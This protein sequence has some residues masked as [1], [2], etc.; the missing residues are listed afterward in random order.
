MTNFV[1]LHTHSD[2]SLLD[3]ACSIS[4]L[5][6][7]AYKLDMPALALTDHGNL[8]GAIDFYQKAKKRKLK[9]LI[10]CEVYVAPTSRFKKKKIG[11]QPTAYHLT[12]LAK[13]KKGYEN[14]M[15]LITGGY[16]EGFYYHPRVDKEF[17]S[18]KGEGLIVLSGCAK[19]EIP[20]LLSQNKVDKAKEICQF[21]KN[22][23]GED[24]YLEVQDVGLEFQKKINS[25]LANLSQE[26]SIPLVAT[27][28][29][30]YLN[31]ED[32]QAQDVLL[33][34][35]TGKTLDDTN[36]LKFSSS[37]L[38]FRSSEEMEK[39]FSHLPQSISNA[40]LISEKCNLELE[41][42]K[43]H[44]PVYRAPDGHNL[45]K[46]LRKLCQERLPHCYPTASAS[47]EQRLETELSIISK[48]GYTGYF[49][50]VWDFISYAKK[51]KI[52]IGPGRG[53]VTGSIVAYLLG[54]TN[55]NPLAY[56]LL[57]ERFLN[58][59]RTAM[60]DI[61]IDIQDERRNEVISYVREKYG[62]ENVAQIITFGTMAARA[63][64]RDVGRV[65]GI[66][67]SR[68]DRIA[69]LIPFNT[70]LKIAIEE[71]SEL[72]EIL[73]EDGKIKTLFEIAQSIEG[74]TRHASTHAAGVVIAPD[75][76]TYYTPLYRTNKNEITTQYEMHS[77]EAIGLLKMDFLGLKTLNVIGDALKIIK[78]NKGKE[79]DLDRISLEDKKAY[80]LLSQ[81]E[82][83]GVFQV[84]SRGMQDLIKK[85]HPER[86][87]DLIAVLALY[88][89][90]PVRMMDDFIDRKQGRSKIEYLHPQL[91]PI[92]KETYGVMLYQ[93]QVMR[94]ANILADFSLGEADILRRAMGKKI[95]RLMEEQKEKFIEG[96]KKKGVSPSL[97]TR[98]FE[99]MAH[100]A[101]YGFNKSHSTGYALISYQTAYLKANYP[102]EFMA[103][104]LTSEIE[105]TDKLSLYINECR[106]MDIKILPPDINHSL[107]HFMV[108]KNK[109]RFALAAI[110]NVGKAAI[111]S[112]LRVREKEGHFS[113][114]F[115]FYR[116][117]NP[118]TVN[119]RMIESLIKS[120][121]FDCLEGSRAQN[122]AVID[123]A[124]EKAA[125]IQQDRE[126]GQLSFLETLEKRE[127][128]ASTER[129]PT[130]EE[131]SKETKLAWE[132][133]L[134]GIYISGHP[135]EKY[136]KIIS[137]YAAHSI[138]DLSGMR[139]EEKIRIV[140]IIS[141]LTSR[142][143]RKGKRMGFFTLEDLDSQVEV[144]VFSSLY[145]KRTS[146]IEEGKLVLIKGK[147]DTASDPPK[148]IAEEIILFSKI[149]DIAHNLHI[150]IK[151]E[152]LKE[153]NLLRLKELL[154]SH[155]GKH[156][157]YL[158]LNLSQGE[159]IIIRSKTM[160]MGFSDSLISEVEDLIGTHS[161]WLGED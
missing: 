3:G 67:Y 160:K 78:K 139:D 85:I 129:F 70:E 115:D 92:L 135:L 91:E 9:P 97:A 113:S 47:V 59:E 39:I 18:Q 23:Y 76:L 32:A 37:E 30:H 51:K 99:L 49:L 101:G 106:R 147:L 36:R 20:F 79:V 15:E 75:K 65:L 81:A 150:D 117:V 16:L 143:D 56:G 158:H 53:S 108:E 161:V 64:I 145:E 128:G 2:Y 44:L 62:K 155:K 159:K 126:R 8:F 10:G 110:K 149:K 24:F 152:E 132:K 137:R 124:A 61:D 14:L 116:R 112:I 118:K 98:I 60:P 57:F 134:L 13:N 31:K 80:E 148:V 151:Q 69:K 33:C 34:I 26:L 104:L 11:G 6:N 156:T 45:D 43:T 83:L 100:F 38:Y 130:I 1:H 157:L 55:I 114:I 154:S 35:Q 7:Q 102:L 25:S 127:S 4:Q 111:S 87:E 41:L 5:I 52:L 71:S 88:R 103:A 95:P 27:N 123:Q 94:I 63:A 133:E 54:I 12:L 109:L 22:L 107:A 144:L 17:L 138:K 82:T 68:V 105:N 48:A 40:E 122:L 131:V 77:I 50:I 140:G 73:K 90:G 120:G 153:K 42:G 28:D 119:K 66:P 58:P 46:Y 72:K 86:F 84:E 89:P 121:A 146:Y 96:A 141:S 136:R 21:Y 19:G 125:Q 142:N 29:V 93:E 74:F